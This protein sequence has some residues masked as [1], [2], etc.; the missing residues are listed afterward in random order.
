MNTKAIKWLSIL[1]LAA[2]AIASLISLIYKFSV[3]E[4]LYS[5]EITTIKSKYLHFSLDDV[6]NTCEN[7]SK[8]DK[9]TIFADS[10]LHILKQWHDKYGIVASLYVQGDFT[11]NSKYAQELI[12]NSNWLKWGY[13]GNTD[14]VRKTDMQIFYKQIKDSI[15][16]SDV[17]DKSPRIHYFHADHTTCMALKN[18]GCSGF[19]T[20]D[21]WSW[22]SKKRE[23]NYYLTKS[24]NVILDKNDRL[25]DADNNIYFIKTDFRLEHIAQRWGDM[26]NCLNYYSTND[27]ENKELIIFSHEWCFNSYLDEADYFFSWASNNGY[28][29]DFPEN[30]APISNN[31]DI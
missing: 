22:N 2:I 12:E 13:H 23:S 20:C 25:Y 17:I 30:R 15:G 29:F 19:L 16:S 5:T 10:T 21:D 14:K 8:Y 24:Q 28:E 18:L 31:K 6:Q 1:S 9:G 11:I 27:A 3:E 4:K 26:N 7:L